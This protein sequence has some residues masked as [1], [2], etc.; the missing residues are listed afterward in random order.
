VGLTPSENSA[1]VIYNQNSHPGKDNYFLT[2]ELKKG[3]TIQLI[4]GEVNLDRKLLF[5]NSWLPSRALSIFSRSDE[6]GLPN[7]IDYDAY[8]NI[9]TD[10]E[11]KQRA[12]QIGQAMVYLVNIE[13]GD[14]KNEEIE[15][16]TSVGVSSCT[17]FLVSKNI[18]VTNR[19]CVM[20]CERDGAVSSIMLWP[21]SEQTSSSQAPLIEDPVIL[22]ETQ[23]LDKFKKIDV[24]FLKI[25]D[26]KIKNGLSLSFAK[27]T[28]KENNRLTIFQYPN[29]EKGIGIS[30]LQVN[31]DIECIIEGVR[32]DPSNYQ[33]GTLKHRCDTAGSSSGSPI[34]NYQ[35]TELVAIHNIGS[36]IK[37]SGYNEGIPV[38]TINQLISSYY[39]SLSP[40]K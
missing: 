29:D 38:E 7:F 1:T 6:N 16:N 30:S 2:P 3:A 32:Y 21:R 23:L 4:N 13:N 34:F 33:D 35:L 25:P 20:S 28:P 24:A 26:G 17:G 5:E 12:I 39:P 15:R 10:P 19:H 36:D 40:K 11:K 31:E 37:N 27:E 9:Q 8:I 18:V 22:N 14:S